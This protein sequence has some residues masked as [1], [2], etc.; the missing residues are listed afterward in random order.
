MVT[1]FLGYSNLIRQENKYI[2]FYL[3]KLIF[4]PEN[5]LF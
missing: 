5:A 1:N 3:I 4:Y 2:I